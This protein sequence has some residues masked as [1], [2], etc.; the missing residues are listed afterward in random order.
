MVASKAVVQALAHKSI[1]CYTSTAVITIRNTKLA[2]V[3]E[4]LD[5]DLDLKI[6][7]DWHWT[8]DHS[9]DYPAVEFVDSRTELLVQLKAKSL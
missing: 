2:E 4:W 1:L 3:F 5:R 8:W 6:G 9:G 7:R